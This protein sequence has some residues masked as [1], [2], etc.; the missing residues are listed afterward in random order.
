MPTLLKTESQ[1]NSTLIAQDL[2]A[3]V[4][5]FCSC[6]NENGKQVFLRKTV[7][8]VKSE[9]YTI[10]QQIFLNQI[11]HL[12]KNKRNM[13]KIHTNRFFWVAVMNEIKNY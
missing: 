8:Q 2:I 5:P 9:A 7:S 13:V 10:A 4:H 6:L 11:S 1:I 12:A 3:S